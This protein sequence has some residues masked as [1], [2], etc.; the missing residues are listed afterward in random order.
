MRCSVATPAPQS[1]VVAGERIEKACQEAGPHS[2]GRHDNHCH[3]LSPIQSS[4][5]GVPGENHLVP[6]DPSALH[7]PGSLRRFQVPF[8]I[9]QTYFA[10]RLPECWLPKRRSRFRSSRYSKHSRAQKEEDLFPIPTHYSSKPLPQHSPCSA[11]P[12]PADRLPPKTSPRYQNDRARLRKKGS[13]EK[14][15]KIRSSYRKHPYFSGHYTEGNPLSQH[16]PPVVKALRRPISQSRAEAKPRRAR[17]TARKKGRADFPSE[18]S[19]L[20]WAFRSTAYAQNS[21]AAAIA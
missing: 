9:F 1:A 11:R 20:H 15:P 18:S 3:Y 2:V 17:R 6:A 16:F 14:K 12:A 19:L 10:N 8:G 21:P 4:H 5:R 7:F 13:I